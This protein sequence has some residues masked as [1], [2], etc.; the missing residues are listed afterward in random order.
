MSR[1][2]RTCVVVALMFALRVHANSL[3]AGVARVDI[4]PPFG[5]EM[6]GFAARQLPSAGIQDPLYARVLVLEGGTNRIAVVTLD[7]G[8][9]FGPDSLDRLRREARSTSNISLVLAAAS[10]T[11]AGPM[12]S[13]HY[14]DNKPPDWESQAITKIVQAIH[15][16]STHLVDVQVGAGY[17]VTYVGYNRLETKRTQGFEFDNRTNRMI[18]SPVDPTVAV[19]RVDTTD[20]K[21]LAI[22]V[23]YACHPVVFGAQNT[24]YSADFPAAM[25]KTIEAA[26]G[27]APMA[28]FLQGGPGDIDPYYGNTPTQQDPDRWRNWTGQQV[29]EEAVRVAKS[30]QTK[31]EENASLDFSDQVIDFRLRWNPDRFYDSFVRTWGPEDAKRYYP[32]GSSTIPASVSTILINKQIA[33]MFLPGEPFVELQMDWRNRCPVPYSFFVGYTNG[34]IGYFPTIRAAVKGGYGGAT[35]ATWV[36]VG[37]GE[38]MVNNA[39]VETYRLLGNLSDS[40]E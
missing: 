12:I 28:F 17:G 27:G 35:G 24:Y 32:G 40:P 36:E 7:L 21:P 23:N 3:K 30:I 1:F 4:T 5:I 37:A 31:A 9:S 26:F 38:R 8:R 16:V 10:H 11:H 22:L 2:F 34:Y 19:L 33:F 15:E 13:D 20:G 18:S 6:W 25:A 14:P 29:G 39:I